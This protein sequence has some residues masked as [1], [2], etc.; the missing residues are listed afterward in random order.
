MYTI[1][2][3]VCIPT[4]VMINIMTSMINHCIQNP[5]LSEGG[6]QLGLRITNYIVVFKNVI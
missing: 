2:Q 5:I 3:I 4:K 6:L 1:A